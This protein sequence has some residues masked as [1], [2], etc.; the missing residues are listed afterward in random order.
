MTDWKL[1][2]DAATVREGAAKLQLY[3]IG[4]SVDD[5]GAAYHAITHSYKFPFVEF[6]L[7]HDFVSNCDLNDTKKALCRDAI[8]LAHSTGVPVCAEGVAS[9]DE[10]QSLVAMGCDMAQGN[11]FGEPQPV[12]VFKTTFFAP[13]APQKPS[14]N[15]NASSDAESFEWPEAVA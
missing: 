13:A 2:G 14:A 15:P 7:S 6:K 4:L 11:V 1:V 9:R 5:I 8:A 10:L 3:G 12:D